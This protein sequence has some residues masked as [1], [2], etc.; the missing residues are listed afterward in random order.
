MDSLDFLCI[1]NLEHDEQI[2]RVCV[3]THACMC[4]CVCVGVVCIF[5]FYRLISTITSV[6]VQSMPASSLPSSLQSL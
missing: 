4:V 5:T 3:Y 2:E 6:I 1:S